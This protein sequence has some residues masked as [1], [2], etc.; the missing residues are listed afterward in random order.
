MK[1]VLSE[2][3]RGLGSTGDVVTVKD[4]Y[5][6]N[7]LLPQKKAVY[8]TE[9]NLN[10]LRKEREAY[11]LKEADRIDA[12]KLIAAKME[13]LEVTVEMKANDAG[14]L[15]GSV[16]EA[17]LAEHLGGA[18][19][20][21]IHA[22]QIIMGSHWKRIGEYLAV[23]RL[24]SEVEVEFP[25]HVVAEAA[26]PEEGEGLEVPEGE[27]E[28]TDEAEGDEEAQAAA[29]DEASADAEGEKSED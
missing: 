19:D 15:F 23:A 20:V 24:H 1:L 2:N 28:V 13:G 4:G 25:V 26:K 21:E 22:Q 6:R 10:R 3:I 12:A 18:I 7:Y 11:L 27:V 29:V 17:I 8:P 9:G 5:A 16:T 14:Q